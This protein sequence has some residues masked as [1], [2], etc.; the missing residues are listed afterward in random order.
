MDTFNN[1]LNPGESQNIEYKESWRDEYLKWIC[2]FAN[3]SGGKL[4]IGIDDD[5]RVVGVHNAERL[6]EDIPNKIVNYLGIVAEVNLHTENLKKYIEI[7]VQPS[8][9]PISFKGIYHY[10]SGSTKQELKGTALQQFIL[11]KMGRSWD[12]VVCEGASLEDIDTDAIAYFMRKSIN[13]KR[14]PD[15]LDNEDTKTVLSNLN[16]LTDDGKLKN[17][18]ILLFGKNP[19]HFFTC[20]DF[21]IGR[22]GNSES[23]LMFNDIIEGNI[24]QMADKVIDVLRSKYLISPIHYEGLQR[25]EPLEIPEDALREAVFNSII[26]KDYTGVQIQMKVYNVSI[27]LWNEG[28]LPNGYTIETLLGKHTSKPRNRNIANVFYKAGFIESWGRGI[29]K[30]RN[31]IIAEGLKEPVFKSEMDGMSVY[32]FRKTK[33]GEPISEPINELMNEPIKNVLR[34]YLD[35]PKI[36]KEALSDKTGKSR[37]TI[38]RIIQYLVQEKYIIRQGSNKTGSWLITEKGKQLLQ[39]TQNNAI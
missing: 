35:N 27:W 6:M 32:F 28:E 8:N 19:A 13:A 3:A 20:A 24:I 21:R 33:D 26:H 1:I 37:A 34:I 39:N 15:D 5:K 10:R 38:T 12:D 9:I 16:L 18:A 17:A 25:I 4:Y 2:G 31:G 36:T 23:D 22:F 7:S 14:M 29:T 30:I 11:R